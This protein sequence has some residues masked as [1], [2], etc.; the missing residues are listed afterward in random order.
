[1][2]Q[3]KYLHF[4]IITESVFNKLYPD[5]I[6]HAAGSVP[7]LE[8][9]SFNFYL[10]NIFCETWKN[11]AFQYGKLYPEKKLTLKLFRYI[12]MYHV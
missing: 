8:E 3:L 12:F 7:F 6:A 1:M 2:E 11:V 5:I 9:C 4:T 10:D